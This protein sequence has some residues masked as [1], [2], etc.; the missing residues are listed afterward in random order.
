MA[1]IH[2]LAAPKVVGSEGNSLL[3]WEAPA[4]DVSPL[5]CSAAWGKDTQAG[6]AEASW[7]VEVGH[8]GHFSLS[9]RLGGFQDS[10]LFVL[11]KLWMWKR[12]KAFPEIT[13][14]SEL[15]SLRVFFPSNAK[16]SV[17]IK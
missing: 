6:R 15:Q 13:S 7:L 8:A 12:K 11:I 17:D 14:V 3:A 16:I 5:P 1:S 2:T 10:E 9:R 4:L